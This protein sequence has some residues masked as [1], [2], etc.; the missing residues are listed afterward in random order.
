M[1]KKKYNFSFG[2]K[3][4]KMAS[5]GALWSSEATPDR[6]IQELADKGRGVM[7]VSN[8]ENLEGAEKAVKDTKQLLALVGINP[9]RVRADLGKPQE[10]LKGRASILLMELEDRGLA[11][12]IFP[13]HPEMEGKIGQTMSI[14]RMMAARAEIQPVDEFGD[15]V[16]VEAG[17]TALFE[18]CLPPLHLMGKVQNM[19]D[20]SESRQSLQKL[21]KELNIADGTIPGLACPARSLAKMEVEGMDKLVETIT[22]NNVKAIQTSGAARLVL[23]A[24]NAFKTF[25]ALDKE[26]TGLDEMISMPE[27]IL[28]AVDDG[29]LL[30]EVNKNVALHLSCSMDEDPFAQPTLAL[31]AL[32]PGLEVTVLEGGCGGKAFKEELDTTE[33]KALISKA[34][35]QGATEIVCTSSFC[36]AH[37]MA[38]ND[39]DSIKVTDLYSLVYEAVGGDL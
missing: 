37:L 26:E 11:T 30:S 10:K 31:L 17:G 19:F 13:K 39:D 15:M 24:P 28:N 25:S 38:A 23:V 4:D 35:E 3:D 9:K 14:M 27:A 8:G 34:K 21:T 29:S 6:I 22:R 36:Q 18:G 2:K 1:M 32:I 7:V 33:A 20:M 5:I 12:I 16:P